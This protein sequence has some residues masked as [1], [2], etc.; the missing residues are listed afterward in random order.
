M[1]C[2]YVFNEDPKKGVRVAVIY[3][4]RERERVCVRCVYFN[5]K[6]VERKK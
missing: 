5:R 6:G 4:Y 2:K 3:I 1:G